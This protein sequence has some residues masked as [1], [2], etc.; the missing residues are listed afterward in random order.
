MKSA[1]KIE[2]LVKKIRFSPRA[3]ANKRILGYAE[4]ALK[5]RVDKTKS[6]RFELNIG[7]IIMKSKITKLAAAA[8]IIIAVVLSITFL[9]KSVTPAYAIEQTIEAFKNV[10][11]VYVEQTHHEGGESWD[12]KMWARRGEDG[13][14]FFG[15]FRQ[16]FEGDI[17]VANEGENLTYYYNPSTKTVYI[18]KGL[19]VTIGNFLDSDFFL[20]LKEEMEDVEIEYGKDEVTRKHTV[21]VTFKQPDKYKKSRSKC[22]VITFDLESK[23]PTRFKLWDNPDFE[24]DPW[25]E[26]TSIVYNPKLPAGIFEFEIPEGTKVVPDEE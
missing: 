16:E 17:T 21:V 14:F 15:D 26:L 5:Q 9:D 23:L 24:G 2:Q 22:G 18:Y 10:N 4:A 1:E 6:N 12:S 7:R 19:T 20:L 3:S 13:K 8:I 25:C 11:S